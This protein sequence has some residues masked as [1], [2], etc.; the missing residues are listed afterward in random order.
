MKEANNPLHDFVSDWYKNTVHGAHIDSIHSRLWRTLAHSVLKGQLEKMFDEQTD[1]SK[2]L[3]AFAANEKFE[4]PERG[5]SLGQAVRHWK[6]TYGL[7]RVYCWHT[8]GGYWGGVSTVSP[9]LA[10]LMP[11][12]V[13]PTPTRSLLEVEPA[14]MW[15]AASL[16]GVGN[17][18]PQHILAFYHGVHGYLAA[19]G[20]DGVK[21]DG[22]SGLTA[23]R[24]SEGT[25]AMVRAHVHAMEASVA[26]HFESNRCINCMCHSTENLY[27]FRSTALLRAADDFYPDDEA[28][29]PVHLA[30]VVYNSLFLAPLGVPDWDMFQ[31]AHPAAGMHAA[32][33]AVGGCQVYVSDAPD[34]HD[35]PLL[36]KLVL[37]DG[38]TLRCPGA[39]RP[40]RDSLFHDP[41]T[42]GESA[43]KVWN[44]NA[45]TGVL[46]AFNLQGA[47]WNRG[48]RG[49][50][51]EQSRMVGV[52]ASLRAEEVEGLQP[53]MTTPMHAAEP[54][55]EVAWV[56]FGH[57]AQVPL[58]LRRGEAHRLFLEPR[59]WEVFT[60]SALERRDGVS[61]AP[62]GLVQMLNGGGA[63]VASELSRR[64]LFGGALWAHVQLRA[65]GEFGAYC[66]PCPRSVRVDG[67]PAEFQHDA[68]TG[69]LRVALPVD[70][71]PVELMVEFPKAGPR[72]S[73][74]REPR[75]GGGAR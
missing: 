58:P 7:Q 65:S 33:R 43:L 21:V 39:G 30:N 53:I 62:L 13:Q 12:N 15:D 44:R 34:A 48:T 23:F 16:F 3:F 24:G 46:A 56:L 51:E 59:E 57:N 54:E 68:A 17:V 67:E 49:F 31:S 38:S 1:F 64:G 36:R 26:E 74:G 75:G 29:Q 32:A 41:N 47:R 22:Q 25:S 61:W 5:T 11:R 52:H 27:S 66:Q 45:L 20:V 70:A 63:L 42:D 18:H 35:F 71:A 69:M 14:L 37:P 28:S 9:E 19:S 72:V 8:I 40:T 4:S 10:H 73:V 50:D 6:D 60:V 2:R 55:P